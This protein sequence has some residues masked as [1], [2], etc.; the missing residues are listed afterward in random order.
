MPARDNPGI[1]SC[2]NKRATSV[3]AFH[4]F[5]VLISLFASLPIVLADE[6]LVP[7]SNILQNPTFSAIGDDPLKGWTQLNPFDPAVQSTDNSATVLSITVPNNAGRSGVE[8]RIAMRR[9]WSKI[10][11][12][13][14]IRVDF[15]GSDNT[16][17]DPSAPPFVGIKIGWIDDAGRVIQEDNSHSWL[18][19]T[20]DWVEINQLIPV[21]PAAV[22]VVL[23]PEITGCSAT[24]LFKHL[25]LVAW[26]QT[27][28]DH[29]PGSS[30]DTTKWNVSSGKH[31]V[32]RNEQEWFLP[33]AVTVSDN[34]L[35]ICASH[36]QVY[37]HAYESGQ[38]STMAKFQQLYG[39]YEFQLKLPVTDGAWP[40]TYLLPWDDDWP[41]EID[42][43]E[44]CGNVPDWVW[45]TVHFSDDY[46]RHKQSPLR[47]N[48]SAQGL[49]RTQ[50]HTYSLVWEPGNISWYLDNIY[51]GSCGLPDTPIPDEPMYIDINLAVGDYSGDPSKSIWP[52]IYSCR[53]VN[54]YQRSDLHLP[55]YAENSQEA[56]LPANTVTLN[57]VTCNPLTQF[58]LKWV[59]VNGPGAAKIERP[60]SPTTS[61]KLRSAGMYHFRLT[62][63]NGE[64]RGD[65][66][67]LVYVNDA[68][69]K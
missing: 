35:S 27:F 50:W 65:D 31:E 62:V 9:E 53:Q 37:D 16:P 11:L 2:R 47:M 33:D 3:A 12:R 30:L 43:S 60:Q 29:F 19:T 32:N 39:L 68:V 6:A 13:G 24:A 59:M 52:Q 26:V 58:D 15:Q 61:V 36:K 55:V 51:R 18:V 66:D 40:A 21:P 41:P 4:I 14:D 46:G 23:A 67:L 7:A 63:A 42:I 5:V 69:K 57:A 25:S 54:V 44:L 20:A 10:L 56:T 64:S 34:T 48:F 1:L 8:Q 17:T 45:Q 22:A 28:E 38:I 49:D